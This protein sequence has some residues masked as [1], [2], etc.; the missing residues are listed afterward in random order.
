MSG[1]GRL[2]EI[3][4]RKG[5]GWNVIIGLYILSGVLYFC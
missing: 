4:K 1:R 5:G 3:G 2:S